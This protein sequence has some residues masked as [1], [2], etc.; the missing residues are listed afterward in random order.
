MAAF[1]AKVE[2]E[3]Y[4]R[5]AQRRTAMPVIPEGARQSTLNF[6]SLHG[7]LPERPDDAGFPAAL[8]AD[9]CRLTLDRRYLIE[10]SESE[11]RSEILGLL[12]E[13]RRE[14]P[15]F[16]YAVRELWSVPPTMTAED[17][18]VVQALDKEI[19][20][21]LGQPPHHVASPGTYDQKHVVR[22]GELKNCVAY[23]PGELE[24]AHQPDEFIEIAD[25]VD[26]A[27]VMAGTTL[28]LLHGET[29]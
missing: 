15:D 11:V 1:M 10:E 29:T 8:V 2:T 4:P 7:G 18:P 14:V 20:R 16:D 26:S 13:L 6:N 5:L 28:R 27:K 22:I 23:G 24:L 12:D 25:M 17:A 9:S 21:V 19:E 3:L